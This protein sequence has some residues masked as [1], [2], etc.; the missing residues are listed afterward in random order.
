ML[1]WLNVVTSSDVKDDIVNPLKELRHER[2]R[3]AHVIEENEYST[4]YLQVQ[5][6]FSNSI[7]GSLNLFR[8]LLQTHPKAKEIKIPYDNTQYYV[9]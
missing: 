3:P 8:G 5:N 2:Q 1:K 9:V 4:D 7:Y 6:K